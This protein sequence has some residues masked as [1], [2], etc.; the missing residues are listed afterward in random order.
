[1]ALSDGVAT[2]LVLLRDVELVAPLTRRER[3]IAVLVAEGR[4][5][6]EVA[7]ACFVSA[8]TVDNHLAKIYDKLGV[9]SRVELRDA[10]APMMVSA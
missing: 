2:P 4:T 5:S 3:E 6:R 10:L 9:R 8:R 7:D 1:M